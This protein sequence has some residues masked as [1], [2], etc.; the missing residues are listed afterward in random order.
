VPRQTCYYLVLLLGVSSFRVTTIASLNLT[1]FKIVCTY[2]QKGL[3]L[4][5]V[6]YGI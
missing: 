1:D 2:L 4:S 5:Y 3:T 6:D